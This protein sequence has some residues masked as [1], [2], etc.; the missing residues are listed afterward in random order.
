MGIR[1]LNR[2][3]APA[4][5]PPAPALAAG[6]STARIPAGPAT[7][8]RRTAAGLGRRLGLPDRQDLRARVLVRSRERAAAVRRLWAD[9]AAGYLALALTLLP[10]TRPAQTLTVFTVTLP[11]GP[12]PAGPRILSQ[13]AP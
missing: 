8:L 3:T 12:A 10:R 6:A 13:R 5:L 7:A 4:P 2:R 11:G 9:M 1:M